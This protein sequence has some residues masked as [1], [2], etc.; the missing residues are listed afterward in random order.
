MKA[1]VKLRWLLKSHARQFSQSLTHFSLLR[2]SGSELV[3][4][5]GDREVVG[6]GVGHLGYCDVTRAE[7][8]LAV[9]QVVTPFADKGFVKAQGADFW[10]LGLESFRPAFESE[11]VV[12]GHVLVFEK[13]QV[14]A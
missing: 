6:A 14:S 5:R 11:G 2:S 7:S 8:S 4:W 12:G 13:V 9:A 3:D 10:E 1:R